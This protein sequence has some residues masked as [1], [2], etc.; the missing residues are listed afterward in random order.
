MD[1]DTLLN[2]TIG[3]VS[4][5]ALYLFK[6]VWQLLKLGWFLIS[7]RSK[8]IR[9]LITKYLNQGFHGEG[10]HWFVR[11]VLKQPK[12]Y[13]KLHKLN[14]K[15]AEKA[16]DYSHFDT[17]FAFAFFA[18][19]KYR[20]SEFKAF[21][22]PPVDNG[23]I[24]NHLDISKPCFLSSEWLDYFIEVHDRIGKS[25]KTYPD[26]DFQRIIVIDRVIM[27]IF[28]FEMP[29]LK[30]VWFNYAEKLEKP[31]F[32]L[33]RNP[34]REEEYSVP[35]FDFVRYVI[36]YVYSVKTIHDILKDVPG[37]AC[38]YIDKSAFSSNQYYDFG[39]YKVDGIDVTYN[40]IYQKG[41]KKRVLQEKVCIGVLGHQKRAIDSYKRDFNKFWALA[42]RECPPREKNFSDNHQRFTVL[43]DK[44]ANYSK[45]FEANAVKAEELRDGSH[46]FINSRYFSS[47]HFARTYMRLIQVV[48]EQ[49][50]TFIDE[51]LR[52]EG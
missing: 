21:L 25:S 11:V 42:K 49:N 41:F 30:R 36:R 5:A 47:E 35:L 22:I 20:L 23:H 44:V 28:L 29:F 27:D 17:N 9:T 13:V 37:L 52:V 34:R 50:E 46:R 31:K 1:R 19:E 12:Y 4:G 14:G 15:K 3:I 48:S 43:C 39:Y 24:I 6:Y 18:K 33:I 32:Q 38:Y 26:C 45:G 40:P 10:G 7:F 16:N 8:A 51:V 2:I